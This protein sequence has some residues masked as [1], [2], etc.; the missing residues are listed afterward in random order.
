MDA[1]SYQP[2]PFAGDPIAEL[3]EN[4][5][6]TAGLLFAAGNVT[7]TLA[8]VVDL[9]ANTIEGCDYAGIFLVDKNMVTSPIHTDP[10]VDEVDDLQTELGE[11]PCIDA[12]AQRAIFYA[13]DLADDARWPRFARRASTAGIRSILAMPLSDKSGFGALNLY[14]RYPGAFGVVDRAKAVILASLAGFALST[15]RT[16][17]DEERLV[18]NLHT[19]L[20]T[21]EVIGQAQGILMERERISPGQAFD[22]LRRASQHLNRKLRDVAQDLVDTGERPETDSP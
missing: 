11:G 5:S 7:E 2:G 17:E 3:T 12:I 9:A 13:A 16:H 20:A 14:A 6:E 1:T 10:V 18:E 8:Q 22:V 15:A 4:F 21:R 19:A